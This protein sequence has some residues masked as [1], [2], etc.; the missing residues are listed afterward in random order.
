MWRKPGSRVGHHR[1]HQQA[2]ALPSDRVVLR[3]ADYEPAQTV[4][5]GVGAQNDGAAVILPK[6]QRESVG[7]AWR[8]AVQGDG[9]EVGLEA[10]LADLQVQGEAEGRH[11]PS[12][13]WPNLAEGEPPGIRVSRLAALHCSAHV[14]LAVFLCLAQSTAPKPALKLS[15]SAVFDALACVQTAGLPARAVAQHHKAAVGPWIGLEAVEAG[16]MAGAHSFRGV[17]Q[18]IKGCPE[19]GVLGAAVFL[20]PR[21]SG[22][23]Q[24]E[25]REANLNLE[26][27]Y[28]CRGSSDN[29]NWQQ[30]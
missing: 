25:V 11:G 22:D 2:E 18:R 6:E 29:G 4:H 26:V 28:A 10:L 12:P 15:T 27:V 7:G 14:R 13:V 21:W 20:V 24:D 1:H 30:P 17:G 3:D 9:S 5:R 8:S 19:L 16:A 23:A